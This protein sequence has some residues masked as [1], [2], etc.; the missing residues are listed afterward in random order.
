MPEVQSL[1]V[2]VEGR[3]ALSHRW[4]VVSFDWLIRFLQ[5]RV[6]AAAGAVE[7]DRLGVDMLL[8]RVVCLCTLHFNAQ[9]N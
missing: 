6:V 4:H 2:H 9:G 5:Y 8:S 3:A 7:V 1:A